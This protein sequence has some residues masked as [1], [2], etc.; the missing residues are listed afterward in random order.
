[1]ENIKAQIEERKAKATFT[2]VHIF[3]IW[4]QVIYKRQKKNN[5]EARICVCVSPTDRGRGLMTWEGV[6][7]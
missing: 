1:M 3:D 5:L 6:H 4:I 2:K 7:S